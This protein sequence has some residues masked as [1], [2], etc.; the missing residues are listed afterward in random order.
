MPGPRGTV[1]V[2]GA[3]IAG[4]STAWALERRGFQVSVFEQGPIPNPRATSYDDHRITRHAYGAHEG[5]AYLMPEAFAVYDR[6][7]KETGTDH[8]DRSKVIYFLREE[9][10]WY[11]PTVRSL[12]RMGSGFRD[13]PLTEVGERFP[14]VQ[15]EGLTRAVE[16]DEG[17]M[18]FPIRILTDLVIHLGNRGVR[19]HADSRVEEV[20]PEAGRVVANGREYRADHVVIAA[21]AWVNTLT[22]LLADTVV[23]SRQAVMYLAPPPELARAWAAAP[24]LIDMGVDSGTYTL[25]PRRG[26]RLKIGDHV[27]TRAG[28]ADGDRLAT[29]DDVARLESAA[30]LGY[31]DFDRYQVLERKICFYTVTRDDSERFAV[32]PWG[33]RA[34]VVSAC[35]GH[36]FKL[37]PLVGDSVAAAI[38]GE[39]AAEETIAKLA[40][41]LDL[42]APVPAPA[43]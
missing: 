10:G 19:F 13:I 15:T 14:M 5:Y 32:R 22:P 35:S 9:V 24:V 2:V 42:A 12:T 34:W 33:R 38:A 21:G 40:G 28:D 3:G 4:L 41:L 6:M 37:G 43:A 16:T 31:R 17:G 39:R 7:F 23:A 20:D 8:F 1:I 26:T 29:D 36:G 30:R 11:E 18:L 27:F 25:P